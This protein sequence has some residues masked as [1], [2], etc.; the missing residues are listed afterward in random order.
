MY[1]FGV[2]YAIDTIVRQTISKV[3]VNLLNSFS[4]KELSVLV[5]N[6]MYPI[7]FFTS[8]FL[9]SISKPLLGLSQ[10]AHPSYIEF[11]RKSEPTAILT[12]HE[13]P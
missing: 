13:S 5:P 6:P 7:Q 8:S 1:S 12:A 11:S 3:I 10:S 4:T 9:F 2:P